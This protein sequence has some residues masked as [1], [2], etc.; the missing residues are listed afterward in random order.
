QDHAGTLRPENTALENVMLTSALP[1]SEARTVLA[2][3]NLRGD[4]VFKPVRVLSG[5]ERAKIA[6][7]KLLLSDCNL[8]IL[9]E[10]TN[11]L[12]LFTMESLEALLAG[13]GGTLLLVSHDRA[14]VSAVATRLLTLEN[15]SLTVFEGTA[16]QKQADAARDR[17][18]EARKLQ[19]SAL[20]MRLAALSARL[21]APRKGDRPDLLNAEYQE[22]RAQLLK[23]R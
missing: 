10:P 7:A 13:Y 23:L 14:F 1:E 3:L 20:E 5:G 15:G 16:E 12:D 17:S 22:V 8:L 4:N 18:D 21:S 9:D 19:I 11:H 2:R 6:L